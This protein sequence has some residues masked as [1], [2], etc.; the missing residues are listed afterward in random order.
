V[1]GF[2]SQ[3]ITYPDDYGACE[4]I[5]KKNDERLCTLSTGPLR[6]SIRT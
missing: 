4:V 6:L 5:H 2:Q 1:S 3:A